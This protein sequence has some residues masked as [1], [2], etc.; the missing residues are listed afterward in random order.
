MHCRERF[1]FVHP[2]QN[3]AITLLRHGQKS[4]AQAEVKSFEK[5]YSTLDEA[6]QQADQDVVK[7]HALLKKLLQ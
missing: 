1:L 7:Q 2:S 5:L 6:A 3:Y 4:R